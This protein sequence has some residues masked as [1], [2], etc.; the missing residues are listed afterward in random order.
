M[1]NTDYD[2]EYVFDIDTYLVANYPKM[3]MQTR[4][5]ICA[6]AIQWFTDEFAEELVDEVVSDYAKTKLEL[7]KL[8]DDEDCDGD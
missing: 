1:M 7:Q 4:R 8:E 5:S 6:L 3:N 2:K